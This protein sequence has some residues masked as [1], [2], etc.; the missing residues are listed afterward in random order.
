M[1][2]KLKTVLTAGMLAAAFAAVPAYAQIGDMK[3]KAKEMAVD[4]AE[5]KAKDE[6]AKQVTGDAAVAGDAAIE[7]GAD[8]AKG[9][10]AKDAV[11]GKVQGEAK[12]TTKTSIATDGMTTGETIKAGKIIAKGGST[13]DAAMEIGKDRMKTKAKGWA[14]EEA[15]KMI[16]KGAKT[17]AE[18]DMKTNVQ[19]STPA[20]SSSTNIQTS[21]SLA[22]N[23][24]A[25]TT[26]QPN[27]T[28]MITGD[29]NPG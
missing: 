21:T 4:K 14:E 22:V 17:D 8:M 20:A 3:D 25:G 6:M 19:T 26:A 1:T 15:G 16:H 27:G 29:Y 7:V 5:D 2:H 28:C 13:T 18:M 9:Q 10:S 24:P 11:M 12:S 23:C